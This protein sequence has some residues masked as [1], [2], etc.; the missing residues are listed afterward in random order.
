MRVTGSKAVEVERILL[1]DYE[2]SRTRLLESAAGMNK[3]Y[4]ALEAFERH[5]EAMQRLRRF[6]SKGQVPEDIL[7]AIDAKLDNG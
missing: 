4:S 3:R 6:L 1:A 5:M 2:N 7:S